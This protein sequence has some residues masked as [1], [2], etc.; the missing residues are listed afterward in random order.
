VSHE[1]AP[2]V[3][4]ITGQVLA[5]IV[6]NVDDD[7]EKLITICKERQ[8]D[9]IHLANIANIESPKISIHYDKPTI[10]IGDAIE[11]MTKIVGPKIYIIRRDLIDIIDDWNDHNGQN[12]PTVQISDY[13]RYMRG[14][15]DK[16]N[17]YIYIYLE[18]IPNYIDYVLLPQ[19]EIRQRVSMPIIHITGPAGAG[20]TTIGNQ[21]KER[22][23]L[24][25]D[26]DTI[27]DD[28]RYTSVSIKDA[29]AFVYGEIS[30]ILRDYH[31]TVVFV[32]LTVDLSLIAS[33]L[34]WLDTD[35]RTVYERFTNRSISIIC[36]NKS[37]IDAAIENHTI[38]QQGDYLKL[39]TELKIRGSVLDPPAYHIRNYILTYRNQSLEV[40]YI[41]MTAE[42]ILRKI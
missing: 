16:F 33:Q 12:T 9:V 8:I 32:G 19:L 22:G 14:K 37:T 23:I 13:L 7:L 11:Y 25:I 30:R 21:L 31:N 10:I 20:K 24:A 38:S 17:N 27:T 15:G 35:P 26:T 18:N 6:M 34:Y 4:Y 42:E 5:N 36:D 28:P 39:M 40:G 2:E 1:G 29:L 41:P 3:L